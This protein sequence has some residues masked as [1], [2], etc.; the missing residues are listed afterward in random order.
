MRDFKTFIK[1]NH[2][3]P[4]FAMGD[5]DQ[6]CVL[7]EMYAKQKLEE[8]KRETKEDYFNPAYNE[9]QNGRKFQAEKTVLQIDK[10]IKEL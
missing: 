3:D 10:T 8:V 1:D 7:A 6:L 9:F 2:P 5:F 4:D